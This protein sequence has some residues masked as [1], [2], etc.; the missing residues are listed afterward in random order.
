MSEKEKQ[1]R[2]EEFQ[3]KDEEISAAKI[4]ARK[5]AQQLNSIPIEDTAAIQAAAGELFGDCGKDLTLKTPFQCD[6]GYNIHLGDNVLINYQCVF[7]DAAP[8]TIGDNCFIG[9]MCGMYTVN[10][11]FDPQRRN[12]GYVYGRPITLEENVWIGGSTTILSGVTIGRNSVIGA[13]SVVTRDIP[14]NVVAAGNPARIIRRLE[15]D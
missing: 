3:N 2:C 6:F 12:A 14:A 15:L 10:H 5:L 1:L 11:P 8:I 9:P 13:G 7:L 4:H